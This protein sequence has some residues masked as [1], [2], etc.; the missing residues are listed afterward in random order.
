MSSH[1]IHHVKNF[2]LCLLGCDRLNIIYVDEFFLQCVAEKFLQFPV[3]IL[4]IGSCLSDK[5]RIGITS[6]ILSVPADASVH[7]AHQRLVRL[8]S[9]LD[10]VSDLVDRLVHLRLLID[11]LLD[12]DKI[13]GFRHRRHIIGKFFRTLLKKPALLDQD[14]S[15]VRKERQCLRQIDDFLLV[16]I[17]P[18]KGREIHR[19]ILCNHRFFQFITILADQILLLAI[20]QIR[21][22][23][24]ACLNIVVNRLHRSIPSFYLLALLLYPLFGTQTT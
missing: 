18:F 23:E 13:R 2:V 8:S 17:R 16:N 22:L 9:E 1:R 10:R 4:H 11:F 3:D 19:V 7:P 5:K 24:F 15:A 14:H 21:L 12:K 6:N 20:Q